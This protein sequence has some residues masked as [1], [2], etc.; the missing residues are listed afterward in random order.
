MDIFCIFNCFERGGSVV[1][2]I[3]IEKNNAYQASFEWFFSFDNLHVTMLSQD[4]DYFL[5]NYFSYLY[6][7]RVRCRKA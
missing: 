7:T 1:E 2:L 5:A 3:A 6:F 4:F